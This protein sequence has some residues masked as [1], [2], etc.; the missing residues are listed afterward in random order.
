M[1]RQ[2]QESGGSSGGTSRRP[3]GFAAMSANRQREIA[4]KGGQAVSQNRNHMAEIGRKGGEASRGGGRRT[5]SAQ[6]GS[7]R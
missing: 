5:G 3:R 1:N 6:G 2:S 4:R 7:G